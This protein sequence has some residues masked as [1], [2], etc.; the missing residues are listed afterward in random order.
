MKAIAWA[1]ASDHGGPGAAR[2]DGVRFRAVAPPSDRR[3]DGSGYGNQIENTVAVHTQ[4]VM[5]AA[6]TRYRLLQI[7]AVADASA[8]PDHETC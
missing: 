6:I 2:H 8:S 3:G 4:T 5:L 7:S 1:A